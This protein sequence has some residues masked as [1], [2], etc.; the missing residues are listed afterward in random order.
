M[1]ESK[2]EVGQMT[3][4]LAQMIEK[5][6]ENFTMLRT[7]NQKLT[8]SEKALK[9][10][11]Q[12]KD[13]FFSIIA[14]DLCS[15]LNTLKGLTNLLINYREGLS[16]EEVDDF[17]YQINQTV[18]NLS[19]LTNNLLTW[20]LA[21][22]EGVNIQMRTLDLRDAVENT[23]KLLQSSAENK[24][25]RLLNFCTLVLKVSADENV[26]YFVLRNLMSNAIKFSYKNGEVK[27]SSVE[28]NEKAFV[29]VIDNGRD[30]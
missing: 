13:K 2:D 27:V 21:Q 3:Q 7:M 26:L 24:S 15:P 30:S 1:L 28:A 12:I 4:D 5:M 22:T 29:Q 6:S 20:A 17:I 18:I 8:E 25:V 23:I 9:E 14:H 19:N 11:N 10:Y 16:K